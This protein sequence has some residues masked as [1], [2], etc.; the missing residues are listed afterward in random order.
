[1]A[2][3]DAVREMKKTPGTYY[4]T[5]EFGRKVQMFMVV[6]VDTDGKVY[7]LNSKNERDGELND[8]G[9]NSNAEVMAELPSGW[10]NVN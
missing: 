2:M 6:E 10:A 4:I 8:E 3:N 1:M 5:N 9:W 7:Q